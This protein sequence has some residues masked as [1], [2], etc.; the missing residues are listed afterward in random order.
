MMVMEDK[1]GGYLGIGAA[2][3]AA[4]RLSGKGVVHINKVTVHQDRLI[5]GWVTIHEYTIQV[6]NQPTWHTQPH[7]PLC[8]GAMSTGD[9]LGHC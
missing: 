4:F 3:S 5:L 6:L 1:E 7:H 9:G 8:V 2:D